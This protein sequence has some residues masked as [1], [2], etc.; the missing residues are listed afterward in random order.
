MPADGTL[1]YC[2]EDSDLKNLLEDEDIE[3]CKIPYSTPK[4]YIEDGITALISEDGI[5]KTQLSIFGK[6][7]LMNLEGA[8]F[9]CEKLGVGKEDFLEAIASFKGASNRLEE[10]RRSNNK[11]MFK[12]FAHSP[13]K[14][15]ATVAAVREQ[16]LNY[17]YLNK[18]RYH[19]VHV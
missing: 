15:A 1:F 13:S 6:H 7:N 10:V 16:F 9:V 14:V 3:V 12:D 18:L 8:R 4:H 17:H 2:E 5:Q 11:V 19:L